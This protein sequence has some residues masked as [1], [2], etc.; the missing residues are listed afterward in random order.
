MITE[1]QG[2]DLA[3]LARFAVAAV[4]VVEIGLLV[5]PALLGVPELASAR[6]RRV[7]PAV[8]ERTGVLVTAATVL[9][10]VT[11][12]ALVPLWLR[13]RSVSW[14]VPFAG[15]HAAV[16]GLGWSYGLPWLSVGSAVLGTLVTALAMFAASRRQ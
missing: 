8:W 6:P 4:L 16:A 7:A 14:L 11:G 3:R 10:A 13:P 5:A 9:L 1:R 15:A 12:S 2:T